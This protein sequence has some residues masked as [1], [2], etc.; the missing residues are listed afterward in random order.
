VEISILDIKSVPLEQLTSWLAAEGH[1]PYRAGQVYG[2]LF[3]QGAQSFDEMSNLPPLL[4]MRLAESYR[5]QSLAE[6]DRQVSEDGTVKWLFQTH[7]G[8]FIETVL[9]P[10]MERGTVCVSTQVGCAMGCAFCRT[11]Q[12][13]LK[14]NLEAGEILEQ[15]L[16]VMRAVETDHLAEVTNIV[17]MGMGEPL[18]N[19]DAVDYACRVLHDQKAFGFGKGRLTVSTSGVAPKIRELVERGTPC[20]LALSLH[21]ANDDVRRQLMP[22]NKTWPLPKLMDAVDFYLRETGEWVT[23]EY[24]LIKDLTCTQEAAADLIRLVKPRRCKVNAIA[25]NASER[26]GLQAPSASEIDS[27]LEQVRAHNIQIHIRNPRGRDIAAACG[28]LAHQGPHKPHP[29][30][31]EE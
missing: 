27:F 26:S 31:S 3:K 8:L 4:R 24:I 6:A 18:A 22:V 10:A 25:M 29:K 19:L 28:Q 30:E 17:F 1:K 23:L 14:R 7:D 2:W 11:A 16:K 13:G 5:I 21:S 12:M 9:I 20:H 15:I